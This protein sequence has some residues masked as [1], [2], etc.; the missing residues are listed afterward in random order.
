MSVSR[1]SNSRVAIGGRLDPA[2]Q[3]TVEAIPASA[4]D[5]SHRK[6]MAEFQGTGAWIFRRFC[7]SLAPSVPG[8]LPPSC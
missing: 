2:M 1:A 7:Y 4:T 3:R 5:P 8:R 6:S